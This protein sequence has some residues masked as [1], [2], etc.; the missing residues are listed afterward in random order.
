MYHP[1][2]SIKKTLN[3]LLLSATV[4]SVTLADP[5]PFPAFKDNTLYQSTT[6]SLSNGQ[7]IFVFA[8]RTNETTN[9]LRR[10]LVAFNLSSIP[11]NA[12][13]TAASLNLFLVKMGPVAP[14]NIT[15]NKALRDWGEGNSNAG[16]PGGHGAPAQTNDATW[17][18][19]FFNTSFWTTPGGDF[20][21]T[22][23]ATAFVEE[24]GRYHVWSGPGLIADVQAWVSNP[25]S[26]FGWAIIGN[27]IDPGSAAKFGTSE[28][29][30][31]PPKSPRLDVTFQ[32]TPPTPTP[33]ATPTPTPT[34]TPTLSP[35]PTSTPTP[36][37]APTL[38][39]GITPSPTPPATAT[40][41]PTVS[42]SPTPLPS[43]TPTPLPSATPTPASTPTPT[44]TPTPTPPPAQAL[45]IS[46]RL[47]VDTG[48]NVLIGGFIVAGRPSATSSSAGSEPRARRDGSGPS[49]APKRVAVRGIGPSLMQ[50]GITDVLADP[51][52]ELHNSSGAL[53]MQ[54]DNWQDD[55]AQAAQ[56]TAL[57][58]GL[59]NPNESGI[60][61]S[62]SPASYTAILA[63]KNGGT[64]VGLVEVYDTN[65]A[66]GSHL[67]NIS[68][69]GLVLLGNNVMI[70]GF[71]LGGSNNTH[72]VVRGIGPSLAPFGLSPV[73]AN[74]TLVLHDGNG[75]VLVANDNWQDDPASAS[76]LTALGLAPQEPAESGI[77]A[78]LPPGAFTAVLA[79]TN[80]GTGIGLVEI[81]N[82]Q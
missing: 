74:P 13:V 65:Q 73:L 11:S 29:S 44:A 24:E 30:T 47:R 3:L 14:G 21:A 62:L 17:L 15:V 52:L 18:H 82:V 68:T 69:R 34:P 5:V 43:A 61:A 41:T 26:N 70:G 40:P 16:S 32:T 57:G 72:V 35:T 60:V 79:G 80:S 66:S 51:T 46:T 38:S 49:G 78:S 4:C 20:L 8:G 53:L 42:V 45:N 75:A 1:V 77:Y 58:L 76:Q 2:G 39:P 7:G 56:L 28:N 54:N 10:G 37:P 12:T 31:S 50:F 36:T 33:T 48:N 67:A 27:E 55:P 59:Q 6:G 71:I 9:F 19:N 81:Y 64:G 23:S 63:G 22:P 25:A